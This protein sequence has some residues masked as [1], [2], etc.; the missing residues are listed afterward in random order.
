MEALE[1]GTHRNGRFCSERSTFSAVFARGK[2]ISGISTEK[3]YTGDLIGCPAEE[4]RPPPHLRADIKKWV[5]CLIDQ[6][7]PTLG[8]PV[9]CSPPGSSVHGGSPG[10]NTGVGC[11]A[12]LQKKW[13]DK[14]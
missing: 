14:K 9:D 4:I 11:H 12:L 3:S 2:K 7:F 13:V 10:K 8:D 6:S 1:K 5:L